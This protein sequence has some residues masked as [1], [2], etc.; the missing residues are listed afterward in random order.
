L[1]TATQSHAT[2]PIIVN[3]VRFFPAR[4]REQAMAGGKFSGSNISS[5]EGFR[6]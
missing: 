2:D 1:A 5:R 6:R 4:E 3:R